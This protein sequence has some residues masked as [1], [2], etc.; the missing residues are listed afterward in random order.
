MGQTLFSEKKYLKK[1]SVYIP[2]HLTLLEPIELR[3]RS[4]MN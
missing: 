1:K 2:S 3:K 4:Y